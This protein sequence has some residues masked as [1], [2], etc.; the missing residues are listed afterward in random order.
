LL[1]KTNFYAEENFV[2]TIALITFLGSIGVFFSEEFTRLVKKILA[3]RGATLV[4]PLFVASWLMYTYNFWILRG[5]SYLRLM[6]QD[7]RILLMSAM[8]FEQGAE[9]VVLLSLLTLFSVTPV[10]VIQLHKRRTSQAPFKYP[11]A[12]STII[13]IISVLLLIVIDLS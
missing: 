8:P 9:S 4:L 2:L 3:I 10:L 11:Y 13:W 12:T 6:L 5:I 1:E 7:V